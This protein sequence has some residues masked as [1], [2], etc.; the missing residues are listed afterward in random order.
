MDVNNE[1]QEKTERLMRLVHAEDLAGVLINSQPNFSW[2]T[3]GGT[4]GVDQSREAGVGTLLVMRDGRRFVLANRIEVSRLLQEEIADQ[5][6][7]PVVFGWEEEKANPALV[8]QLANSLIS[9]ELR[10]GSDL[11]MGE[12]RI[13]E[14]GIARARYKLT[15]PETDRFKALGSDAGEAIGQ[16]ARALSPG[17]TEREVA[18]RAVDALASIGAGA[19]VTLV[20]ADD[21]LKQFRHPVPTDRRWE[22]VL[23]IVVC[24]RRRGLIASLT[25]IVSAGAIPEELS[26]RTQATA[27]VNA[28]LFAA[29]RPGVSGR[30]LYKVAAR[31][32]EAEGFS[33]E[34]RLHHQGGASGYRTRDWVAHPGQTEQV[35]LQQAFAWN[36]SITGS[37]V[38]ETCIAFPDGIEIITATPGWPSI[39][40]EVDGREYLLPGV[41]SI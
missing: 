6:Y 29:T 1:I 9:E 27:R 39:P 24:A 14:S 26:N 15:G 28:M 22:K 16:M 21:R 35:Q 5:G 10:L 17:L 31:A 25:R 36:P 20:A 33:G 41:L 11:P 13:I 30:E 37:K 34:E 32:Y 12:A 8:T 40:V 4:N 18:R 23:M 7:E 2:L 38:E 19:V 3:A